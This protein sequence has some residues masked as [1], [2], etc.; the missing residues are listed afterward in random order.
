M[1]RILPTRS[2]VHILD[3]R[4]F[5]SPSLAGNVAST[6]APTGS[7]TM[8]RDHKQWPNAFFANLGLFT[9]SKAIDRRA[10][11]DVETTDWRAGAGKL[12]TGFGGGDGESR[13]L[14]LSHDSKETFIF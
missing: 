8:L 11:P 9:M 4:W 12:H 3:N 7:G 13:S 14:P 6:K 1:V 10:N 2:P 5:C